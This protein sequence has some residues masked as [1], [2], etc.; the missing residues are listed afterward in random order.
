MSK[1][2][3]KT[4][5]AALLGGAI[6][7]PG[8]AEKTPPQATGDAQSDSI[9]LEERL[10][11]LA[12]IPHRVPLEILPSAM[13]YEIAAPPIV[14]YVCSI[15]GDTVNGHYR[16][17]DVEFINGIKSVVAEMKALDYD[18]Q[19]DD[20]EFCPR[21]YGAEVQ[22]PELIFRFRFSESAPYHEARSNI[23]YEYDC[24]LAFLQDKKKFKDDDDEWVKLDRDMVYIIQKMLP[25]GT[26]LK[27]EENK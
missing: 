6:I 24:T 1:K 7:V 19:I 25:I 9:R 3:L 27:I 8:C 18:V 17:W 22:Q 11:K 15:C 21:C 5:L 13:C 14:D 2:K 23:S 20:R 16:T 10:R 4:G 12:K 26:G